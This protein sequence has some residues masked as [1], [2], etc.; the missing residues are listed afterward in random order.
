MVGAGP[1][2]WDRPAGRARQ[3]PELAVAR[4]D[5]KEVLAQCV[6]RPYQVNRHGIVILTYDRDGALSGS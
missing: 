3:V 1:R 4:T 2:G 5:S 6:S